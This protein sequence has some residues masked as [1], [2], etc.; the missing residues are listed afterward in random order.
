MARRICLQELE[1]VNKCVVNRGSVR[2]QT[3]HESVPA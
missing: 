3:H 2:V 1:T